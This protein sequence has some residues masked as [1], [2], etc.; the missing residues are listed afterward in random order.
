LLLKRGR[1]LFSTVEKQNSEAVSFGRIPQPKPME[2][3]KGMAADLKYIEL[4][5]RQIA[6]VAKDTQ[7]SSRKIDTSGAYR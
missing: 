6:K 4:C 5:A 1:N 3:G 7:N 2:K